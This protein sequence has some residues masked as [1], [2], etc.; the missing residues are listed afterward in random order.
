MAYETSLQSI[1]E[2]IAGNP[3]IAVLTN[4]DDFILTRADYHYLA[5]TFGERAFLYPRGGHG[6]NLEHQQVTARM[7]SFLQGATP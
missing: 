4:A 2:H 1:E 7:L 5:E 3:R 6:G